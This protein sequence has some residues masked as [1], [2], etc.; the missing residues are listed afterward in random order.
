MMGNKTTENEA[1]FKYLV[2]T[3]TNYVNEEI[4]SRLNLAN[5]CYHTVK[6]LLPSFCYVE[7]T[8]TAC[9]AT[10]LAIVLYECEDLTVMKEYRLRV[11]EY[12]VLRKVF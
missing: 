3:L 8:T 4:K 9:R 2:M 6:N 10:I 7:T 5:A 12:R 1:K 11:F